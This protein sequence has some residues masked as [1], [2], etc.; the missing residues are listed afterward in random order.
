PDP[1]AARDDARFQVHDKVAIIAGGEAEYG[2]VGVRVKLPRPPKEGDPT[3]PNLNHDPLIDVDQVT[4]GT[5]LAAWT[6]AEVMPVPRIKVTAGV[7]VDNFRRND[8]VVVQPRLQTRFKLDKATSI[9][10]AGGLYTR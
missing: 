10:A 8:A 2:Q 7:R 1:I 9:L 6:A 4:D 3:Q 5:N